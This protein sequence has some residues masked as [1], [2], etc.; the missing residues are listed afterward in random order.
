MPQPNHTADIWILDSPRL[1][2]Y[3]IGTAFRALGARAQTD[4]CE[5]AAAM[6]GAFG[7]SFGLAQRSVGPVPWSEAW[8]QNSRRAIRSELVTAGCDWVSQFLT[9]SAVP[10]CL[11]LADVRGSNP[12]VF[13]PASSV[14]TQ[15]GAA[16]VA[17]AFRGKARVVLCGMPTSTNWL[18]SQVVPGVIVG[19]LSRDPSRD[20]LGWLGT[21]EKLQ[22]GRFFSMRPYLERGAQLRFFSLSNG[23]ERHSVLG[24][25]HDA[26][27]DA[28]VGGRSLAS[29]MAAVEELIIR[30]LSAAA[31]MLDLP[32]GSLDDIRLPPQC[33]LRLTVG[34]DE[35]T[36]GVGC[37]DLF[38]HQMTGP[39]R[40]GAALEC[41]IRQNQAG[42][43]EDMALV[44]AAL[45]ANHFVV[46]VSTA[47]VCEVMCLASR[48]PSAAR[49]GQA[50]PT[51]SFCVFYC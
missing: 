1:R 46:N 9:E 13:I 4:A 12:A 27:V 10:H 33:E 14:A 47:G 5:S 44:K 8:S 3:R 22:S 39:D 17:E 29:L 38:S 45:A 21:C 35:S 40:V 28:E 32:R 42:D 24:N 23:A 6:Y 48:R 51:R 15:A 19:S 43:G 30:S 34:A 2:G 18:E 7:M 26:L 31:Q 37:C 20:R 25:V 16:E 11:E 41:V 50:P 49:R 36:V